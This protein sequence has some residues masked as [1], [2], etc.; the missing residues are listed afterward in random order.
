M[1]KTGYITLAIQINLT[2]IELII[3][4]VLKKTMETKINKK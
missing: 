2:L 4:F 1:K 3:F